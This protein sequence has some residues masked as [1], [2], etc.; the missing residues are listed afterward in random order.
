MNK[1]DWFFLV[2]RLFLAAIILFL[3]FVL[4]S[5]MDKQW[6]NGTPSLDTSNFSIEDSVIFDINAKKGGK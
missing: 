2:L 5:C 3:F 1:E 6:R 4:F